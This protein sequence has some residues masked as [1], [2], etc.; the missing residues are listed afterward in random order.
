MITAYCALRLLERAISEEDVRRV[1]CDAVGCWSSASGRWKLQG[2]DDD[3]EDLFL[4]A[5]LQ[6]AVV[7]VTA[8]RGD[9]D[10][11]VDADDEG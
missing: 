7:V 10:E 6:E 8:F 11:E 9:E 2:E 5:E 4:I 3:G 1:L